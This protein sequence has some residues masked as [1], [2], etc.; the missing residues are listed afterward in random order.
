MV[1]AGAIAPISM[2]MRAR[3]RRSQSCRRPAGMYLSKGENRC[4]A[5]ACAWSRDRHHHRHR[6]ALYEASKNSKQNGATGRQTAGKTRALR[7]SSA[8]C[9]MQEWQ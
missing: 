1:Y 2:P 8:V 6:A 4:R 9:T 7:D 5:S 3:A